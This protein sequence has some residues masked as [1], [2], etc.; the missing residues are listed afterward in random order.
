MSTLDQVVHGWTGHHFADAELLQR[1]FTHGS[2][3]AGDPQAGDYE[4]LEFLGDGAVN[5]H[6]ALMLAERFPRATNER[7]TN[8]RQRVVETTMLGQQGRVLGLDRHVRLGGGIAEEGRAPVRITGDVVEALFG[9]LLV[10]GGFDATHAFAEAVVRPLVDAI[11]PSGPIKKAV[12]RLQE[13]TQEH[14]DGVLPE[15]T[16]QASGPGHALEFTATVS[17]LGRPLATG[18]GPSKKKARERAAHLALEAL[19]RPDTAP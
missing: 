16:V 19:A 14:H 8:M 12:N 6:A 15:Y 5:L 11:D 10:E 1:A 18:V 3:N 13:Y 4:R 7:L 2:A 9:A 17:V